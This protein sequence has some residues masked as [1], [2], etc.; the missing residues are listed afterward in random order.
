[1]ILL[2]TE[3][4]TAAKEI[5]LPKSLEQ[6]VYYKMHYQQV[7]FKAKLRVKLTLLKHL[8]QISTQIRQISGDLLT[9]Q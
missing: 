9:T 8:N 6:L 2:K 7:Y 4:T 3:L 1:M 5:V